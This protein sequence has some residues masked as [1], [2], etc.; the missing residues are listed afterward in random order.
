MRG[1]EADATQVSAGPP[2]DALEREE[3]LVAMKMQADEAELH[4]AL[5]VNRALYARQKL[6]WETAASGAGL[7]T[8]T[9]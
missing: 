3:R 4:R 9:M 2:R 7:S 8:H 5:S 1:G 6:F